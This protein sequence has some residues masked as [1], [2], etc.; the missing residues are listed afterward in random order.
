MI[1][2]EA[3]RR[4]GAPKARLGWVGGWGGWGAQCLKEWELQGMGA[5]CLK[6]QNNAGGRLFREKVWE[7]KPDKMLNKNHLGYRIREKMRGEKWSRN[8]GP[9]SALCN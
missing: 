5:Q 4:V 9:T 1:A 3:R 7:L 6:D 2:R 8:L